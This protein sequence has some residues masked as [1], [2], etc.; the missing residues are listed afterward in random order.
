MNFDSRDPVDA[1]D[2]GELIFGGSDPEKY[3]EPFTY[4]PVT[5]Q[6]YWQFR[7]DGCVCV[8]IIRVLSRRIV[9]LLKR[10]DYYW[11]RIAVGEETIAIVTQDAIVDTGTGLIFGPAKPMEQ[12]NKLIG[13]TDFGEGT[14]NVSIRT[15]CIFVTGRVEKWVFYTLH[16]HFVQWVFYRNLLWVVY[17]V[18]I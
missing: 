4:V 1:E 12:I 15:K 9:K 6:G 5:E 2:V 13:A 10:V 16:R 18:V 17:S 3:E 14:Y 7:L 11:Y 8:T